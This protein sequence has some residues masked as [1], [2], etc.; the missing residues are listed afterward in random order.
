MALGSAPRGRRRRGT[1]VRRPH[2]LA[3]LT[4]P[5]GTPPSPAPMRPAGRSGRRRGA[6]AASPSR[7]GST[8]APDRPWCAPSPAAPRPRARR[9]TTP[10]QECRSWTGVLSGLI[11]WAVIGLGYG[12]GR[13]GVLART[14]PQGRVRLALDVAPPPL[15][16]RRCPRRTS[17][18]CSPPRRRWA[19][20]VPRGSRCSRTGWS[21]GSCSAAMPPRWRRQRR[22]RGRL[23]AANLGIPIATS[24]WGRRPRLAPVML[25]S[26]DPN[27]P[28]T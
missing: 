11:V 24:C 20:G 27:T 18:G 23:N 8:R 9:S 6:A 16:S 1:P 4:P 2:R 10:D 14:P 17:T 26:A 3:R 21:P 13:L 5:G 12:I 22:P 15:P 28:R 25:F 19:A 7:E